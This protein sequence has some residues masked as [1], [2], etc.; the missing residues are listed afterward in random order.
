[1]EGAGHRVSE[2]KPSVQGNA[3]TFF[4]LMQHNGLALQ[5]MAML[6][7][8]VTENDEDL[9]E[10]IPTIDAAFLADATNRADLNVLMNV[11]RTNKGALPP[12]PPAGAA[13]PGPPRTATIK[14]NA[15]L[16]AHVQQYI[17]MFGELNRNIILASIDV[18]TEAKV[19]ATLACIIAQVFPD[20]RVIDEKTKKHMVASFCFGSW[21]SDSNNFGG[22]FVED[23]RAWLQPDDDLT[24]P[25]SEAD[26]RTL[27]F[28]FF[29]AITEP[30][31]A[32][33]LEAQFEALYKKMMA[34]KYGSDKLAKAHLFKI[35][36]KF[37]LDKLQVETITVGDDVL[38]FFYDNLTL[39]KS[40]IV[41]HI[42]KETRRMQNEKLAQLEQQLKGLLL[43][44]QPSSHTRQMAVPAAAG[45]GTPPTT[46]R[47]PA[48]P[49]PDGWQPGGANAPVQPS[50]PY[51]DYPNG[52]PYP[53]QP[54]LA[55][56]GNY[57][58][59]RC[60]KGFPHDWG[61]STAAQKAATTAYALQIKPH[62]VFNI[63]N[64][65][66]DNLCV[67]SNFPHRITK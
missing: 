20:S 12:A 46:P 33:W 43:Q 50:A 1:M 31:I 62:N 58:H 51:P 10:I 41:K 15:Q 14:G 6:T 55:W 42:D 52:L 36:I 32:N 63:W 65:W 28:K 23:L 29:G 16:Q 57:C 24:R 66:K 13:A 48:L 64:A 4:A 19:I 38:Q 37:T 11:Y 17:G 21:M 60:K 47:P 40:E 39:M 8:M 56:V 54:C 44:A 2:L 34:G 35:F 7:A 9:Y 45:L 5:A 53:S 30:E 22:K 67:A 59:T 18:N 26:A 61:T 49:V 3:A 27:M 25:L